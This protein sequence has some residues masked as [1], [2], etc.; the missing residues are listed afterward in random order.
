MDRSTALFNLKKI[1]LIVVIGTVIGISINK[2]ILMLKATIFYQSTAVPWFEWMNYLFLSIAVLLLPIFALF[3]LDSLHIR[4]LLRIFLLIIIFFN[5]M[6]LIEG[7]FAEIDQIW[8]F[9]RTYNVLFIL[10]ES[11]SAALS[12]IILFLHIGGRSILP[13][14]ITTNVYA[15]YTIFEYILKNPIKNLI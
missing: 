4:R 14:P 13:I 10:I 1:P 12:W 6:E 5:L 2:S 7:I 11:F 8:L 15:G 9:E 3:F